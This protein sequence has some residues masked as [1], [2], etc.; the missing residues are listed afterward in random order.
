MQAPNEDLWPMFKHILTKIAAECQ[1]RSRRQRRANGGSTRQGS[2]TPNGTEAM[3]ADGTLNRVA[4]AQN[5]SN[6]NSGP[7]PLP[8]NA[9]LKARLIAQE[10]A[11]YYDQ[12]IHQERQQ[13]S[14]IN[15]VDPYVEED[16]HLVLDLDHTLVHT[17]DV[18][19]NVRH[20]LSICFGLV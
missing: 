1:K 14:L 6:S 9:A 18:D 20:M 13:A 11:R 5:S 15:S 4:L 2:D 7:S 19:E 16:F 12:Q 10:E 8:L 3:N 17:T